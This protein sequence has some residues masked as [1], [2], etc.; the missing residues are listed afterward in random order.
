MREI[1][2][3]LDAQT[4]VIPPQGMNRI[5][6]FNK[7]NV[8]RASHPLM[9]FR[10]DGIFLDYYFAFLLFCQTFLFYNISQKYFFLT[11]MK[12]PFSF[13]LIMIL[14]FIYSHY[15]YLFFTFIS[16]ILIRSQIYLC[17]PDLLITRRQ[18]YI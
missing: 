18:G 15:H 5:N 3:D 8:A 17:I 2:R 9:L 12:N 14:I 11:F 1:W 10:L 13:Y 7:M 16:F 6:D 4:E